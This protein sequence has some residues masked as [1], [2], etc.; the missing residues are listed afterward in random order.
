[1]KRHGKPRTIVTDG[2]WSYS[3]AMNEIGNADR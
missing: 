2:V 3:A 1:M